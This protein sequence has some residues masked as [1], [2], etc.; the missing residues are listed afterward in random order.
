MTGEAA[1]LSPVLLAGA[2][3]GA[4]LTRLSAHFADRLEPEL[5]RAAGWP[6]RLAVLAG[7]AH[8][9]LAALVLLAG[10]VHLPAP[11]PEPVTI[12]IVSETTPQGAEAPQPAPQPEPQPAPATQP[13]PMPPPPIPD[14][15]PPP[16]G[17]VAALPPPPPP[18]PHR[19]PPPRPVTHPAGGVKIQAEKTAPVN[20]AVTHPAVAFADNQVPDYPQSAIAAREQGV[21]RF[22]LYLSAGGEVRRFVLTQS[23]GYADLDASVRAA[24]LGWRYQPAMRHGVAVPSVVQF[25]V[26]FV[27]Q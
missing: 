24:A 16:P 6:W 19:P 3:P 9:V 26:Q 14:L 25:H 8:L 11:P 12:S 23:S 10:R 18:A 13:L 15:P 20:V 27:P 21:V 5:P 7:A 4:G 22:T 2:P 17:P 1:R